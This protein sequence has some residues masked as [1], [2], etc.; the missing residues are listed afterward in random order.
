M[1]ERTKNGSLR[2]KE[3]EMVVVEVKE[4]FSNAA[5]QPGI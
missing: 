3:E 4:R 1:A 2:W 5:T